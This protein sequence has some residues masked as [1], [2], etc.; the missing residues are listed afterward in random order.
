M[1]KKKD[2]NE[3]KEKEL[4]VIVYFLCIANKNY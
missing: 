4:N 2:E 1:R 3:V